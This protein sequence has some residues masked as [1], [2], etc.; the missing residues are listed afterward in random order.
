MA[1]ACFTTLVHLVTGSAL[2]VFC[3]DAEA[4]GRYEL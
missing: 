4:A 2:I 1:G 3:G